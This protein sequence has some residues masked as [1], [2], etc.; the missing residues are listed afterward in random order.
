[1]KQ[2]AGR[3][4]GA[5]RQVGVVDPQSPGQRRRGAVELLVE[6]VPQ[7]TDRLSDQQRRGHGV[8]QRSHPQAAMAQKKNPGQD[9]AGDT[10][11]DSQAPL[12]CL[13][14]TGQVAVG[15]EVVVGR[16]DHVVETSS[17]DSSRHG[18]D[19]D[20]E[21]QLRSASPGP[22]APVRPPHGHEDSGEDAQRIGPHRD[23]AEVPHG[24]GRAR[25]ARS[26][27]G[28]ERHRRQRWHRGHR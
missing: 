21:D 3:V 4:G 9:P 18:H 7:A 6:P 26:Q 25:Y 1:M 23:G 15:A 17:H 19:G 24:R 8:G 5:R 10:S 2:G 13:W 22:V 27:R 11:P 20:V 12:P 16:G 14:D 28:R